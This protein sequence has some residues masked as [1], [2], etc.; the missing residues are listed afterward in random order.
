MAPHNFR[1][2]SQETDVLALLDTHDEDKEEGSPSE[3]LPVLPVSV[4]ESVTL[5]EMLGG[6]E[7]M[8]EQCCRD[9]PVFNEHVALFEEYL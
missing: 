6:G 2:F 9:T 7:R 3:E 8:L 4:L 1:F 5:E